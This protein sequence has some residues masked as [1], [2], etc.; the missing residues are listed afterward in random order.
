MVKSGSLSGQEE[1]GL[2]N[3]TTV[4]E[5]L[6]SRRVQA[7][8]VYNLNVPNMHS[9][10][11]PSVS[12]SS[13]IQRQTW[14]DLPRRLMTICVGIPLLWMIWSYDGRLRVLFFQG[15]HA[16]AAYEW[17]HMYHHP[18]QQ[19]ST[20]QLS[21]WAFPI[22]SVSLSNLS[23]SN[24]FLLGLVLTT[25][26]S[27]IVLTTPQDSIHILQGLVLITIPF[28]SW[29]SVAATS[30]FQVVSLL[31]TVW[32]CD[33]GA[34]VVGRICGERRRQRSRLALLHRISPHKSVE[35]LGGGFVV[36]TI[37]Y[38]S[39]PWIWTL[40]WEWNIPMGGSNTI[41]AMVAFSKRKQRRFLYHSM[42]LQDLG[43]GSCLSLLAIVGDLWESSLKRQYAVKDTGTLLPGH[44]G[45]LDRFDSSL[46]AVL[47]YPW[48][49]QWF[50]NRPY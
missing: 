40:L 36:G 48:I 11:T 46:L 39:L 20:K 37:T 33:T 15:T 50:P 41:A 2:K 27:T 34:L 14:S 22:L 29:I 21:R 4:T 7:R 28:R 24:A 23:D 10:T 3:N 9:F 49:L 13:I 17:S 38:V 47:V 43:I 42:A 31:L 8:C 30:F 18:Q 16:L 25:A 45:I 6:V 1:I 26:L 32:N 19:R 35:G 12:S 44:G 5:W